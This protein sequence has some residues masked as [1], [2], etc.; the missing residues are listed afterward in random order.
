MVKESIDDLVDI[1]G[2]EFA[3][4]ENTFVIRNQQQLVKYMENP[5]EWKQ[6]QLSTRAAYRKELISIAKSQIESINAKIE[7]VYLLSYQAVDK[8]NI[9]IT[10]H[11][12]QVGDIPKEIQ[13]Q[14]G[15]HSITDRATIERF[16]GLLTQVSLTDTTGI[17]DAGPE[18]FKAERYLEIKTKDGR[19]IDPLKYEGIGGRFFEF[20]GLVYSPLSDADRAWLAQL[21]S[22]NYDPAALQ[23]T[24]TPTPKP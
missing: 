7:K 12:I 8:D 13:K 4:I 10:E 19:T 16:Y 9:I 23:P 11:E 20:G 3:K 1:L 21:F 2:D 6:K 18:S 15:V 24:A 5:R 22:I 17:F 14:I